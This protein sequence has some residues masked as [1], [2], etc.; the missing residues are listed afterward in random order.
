MKRLLILFSLAYLG[1]AL[2]VPPVV[3]K[4]NPCPRAGTKLGDITCALMDP[5]SPTLTVSL[6]ISSDDGETWTVLAI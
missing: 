2:A 4:V 3:S 1:S 6:E 5:D